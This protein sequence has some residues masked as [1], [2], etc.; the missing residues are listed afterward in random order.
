M[1]DLSFYEAEVFR[2]LDL[3]CELLKWY[4]IEKRPDRQEFTEAVKLRIDLYNDFEFSGDWNY[5]RRINTMES[6]TKEAQIEYWHGVMQKHRAEHPL[7]ITI[8]PAD[9]RKRR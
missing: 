2:K 6:F 3:H 5:I 7:P 1:T 9:S 8:K 4:N